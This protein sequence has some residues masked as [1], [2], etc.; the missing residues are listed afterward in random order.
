EKMFVRKA[1]NTSEDTQRRRCVFSSFNTNMQ[2][3]TSF[4]QADTHFSED[5]KKCSDSPQAAA[6]FDS[7][8][9]ISG[10][11]ITVGTPPYPNPE[12]WARH[13]MQNPVPISYNIEKISRM[14]LQDWFTSVSGDFNGTAM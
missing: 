4:A 13:A 8:G 14:F 12:E 9:L 5:T 2:V 10:R 1:A 11:I 7:L 3:N 6:V